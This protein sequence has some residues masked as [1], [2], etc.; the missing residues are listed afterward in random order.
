MNFYKYKIN[1][2]Y[3]KYNVVFI[4]SLAFLCTEYYNCVQQPSSVTAGNKSSLSKLSVRTARFELGRCSKTQL[5]RFKHL[6]VY[7]LTTWRICFCFYTHDYDNK[8]KPFSWIYIHFGRRP[9][10]FLLLSSAFT[11]EPHSCE[12]NLSS[13]L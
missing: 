7:V 3:V 1:K 5:W 2:R 10:Q 11:P 13:A 8:I 6:K 9:L 12:L 4:S